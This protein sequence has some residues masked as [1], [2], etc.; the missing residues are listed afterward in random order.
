M[1]CQFRRTP[2]LRQR[3]WMTPHLNGKRGIYDSVKTFPN[4]NFG[5]NM[6]KTYLN[7]HFLIYGNGIVDF[8]F[9]DVDYTVTPKQKLIFRSH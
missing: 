2:A 3:R 6:N 9:R 7:T 4:Y 5:S 1:G 8:I